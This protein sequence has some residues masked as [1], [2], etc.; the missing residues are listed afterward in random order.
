MVFLILLF[1]I[2]NIIEQKIIKYLSSK[3]AFFY[4][5]RVVQCKWKLVSWFWIFGY[6]AL[7]KFSKSFGNFFKGVCMNPVLVSFLR[8]FQ[9]SAGVDVNNKA[10]TKWIYKI[11]EEKHNILE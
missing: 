5:Y 2:Q 8:R 9:Q 3:I 7:E 11:S 1:I 6:L 4:Y 10:C